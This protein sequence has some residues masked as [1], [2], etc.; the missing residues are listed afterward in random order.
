[1]PNKL[2]EVHRKISSSLHNRKD[3]VMS[4]RKGARGEKGQDDGAI[5]E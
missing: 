3:G 4:D 5:E 1:M 2:R